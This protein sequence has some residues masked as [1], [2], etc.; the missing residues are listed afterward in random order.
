[1]DICVKT[2]WQ[3]NPLIQFPVGAL[4]PFHCPQVLRQFLNIFFFHILSDWVEENLTPQCS[5]P[6]MLINYPFTQKKT[7]HATQSQ[8]KSIIKSHADQD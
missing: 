4:T 2:R 1:M 3:A 5:N 6:K 7:L 8:A